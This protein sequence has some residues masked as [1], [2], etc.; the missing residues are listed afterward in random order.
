MAL[1]STQPLTEMITRN[2]CGGKRWLVCKADNLTAICELSRLYKKCGNLDIS[3]SNGPPWPVTG[4]ALPLPYPLYMFILLTYLWSWALLEKLP[5]VQPSILWNPKVHYCV[6]KSPPL[7]PILSQT[8]PVHTIPS[9]SLSLRSILILS[10]H[11]RLGLPSGSF[12]LAFPPISYMQSSPIRATCP[13]H[14]ILL[15]QVYHHHYL[16]TL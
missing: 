11:P 9:H 14:L 15:E 13:A 7:V 3:L 5:I 8:D 4:I 1:G 10:T 16:L 12:L 2:L 6:H